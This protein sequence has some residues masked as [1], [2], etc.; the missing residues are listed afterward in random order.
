MFSFQDKIS[1]EF[2]E[3]FFKIDNKINLHNILNTKNP[4][5][6]VSQFYEDFVLEVLKKSFEDSEKKII[7]NN[8]Y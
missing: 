1:F 6:I 3:N 2:K 4:N 8:K 5:Y 7:K